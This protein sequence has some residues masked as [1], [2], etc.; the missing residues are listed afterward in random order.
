MDSK[1]KYPSEGS[2][3]VRRIAEN[4]LGSVDADLLCGDVVECNE[5]KLLIPGMRILAL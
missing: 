1:I 2:V 5:G 4:G 3:L